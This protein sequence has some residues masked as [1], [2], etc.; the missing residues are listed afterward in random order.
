MKKLNLLVSYIF[1]IVSISFAQPNTTLSLSASNN[2]P[3]GN[4]NK[5]TETKSSFELK[6]NP[7]N[8]SISIEFNTLTNIESIKLINNSSITVFE[9]G[10]SRGVPNSAIN[11]PIEDMESGTYFIRV[12]TENGIEIQRIIISK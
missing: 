7:L 3:E 6:S 10:K 5:K 9:Q 1:L 8:E 4:K 11:I 2:L 12:Q